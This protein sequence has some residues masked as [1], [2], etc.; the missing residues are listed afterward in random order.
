MHCNN[1]AHATRSTLFYIYIESI[2]KLIAT[3]RLHAQQ[4]K[5][6]RYTR[7][8]S[9]QDIPTASTDT[10]HLHSRAERWAT[11][12]RPPAKLLPLSSDVPMRLPLEHHASLVSLSLPGG[13]AWVPRGRRHERGPRY[14][15]YRQRCCARY[16]DGSGSLCFHDG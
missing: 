3:H 6:P 15:G 8:S 13:M 16:H 14:E 12:P 5:R 10:P 1:A 7:D 4:Q 11:P 9:G 2:H